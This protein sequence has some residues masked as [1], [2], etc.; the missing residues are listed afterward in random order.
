MLDVILNGL[1]IA[2][3]LLVSY[4]LVYHLGLRDGHRGPR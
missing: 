4:V 2:A 1:A 3:V